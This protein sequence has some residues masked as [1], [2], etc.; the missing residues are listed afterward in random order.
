MIDLWEMETNLN[1]KKRLPAWNI[2]IAK[3]LRA[4]VYE[5]I[6]EIGGGKN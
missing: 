3:W 2:S 6:L 1:M 4:T 5:P